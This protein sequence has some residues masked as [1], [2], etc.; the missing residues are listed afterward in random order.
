[1]ATQ[2]HADESR[3]GTAIPYISHLL[4]VSSLVLEHGGNE[5]EAIDALRHDAIEDQA[6]HFGGADALRAEIT[7][8]FGAGVTTIVDGC[9]DAEVAPKPPWRE[10][11]ETYVAHL[12]D[13]PSSVLLVL[14]RDKLHNARGSDGL[15]RVQ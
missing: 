7:S 2:L 3:K 9:T 1:M 11:K 14:A 12:Q 13:V 8:R 10:R 6:H 4:A 5:N 15:S